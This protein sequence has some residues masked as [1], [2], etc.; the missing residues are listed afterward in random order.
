MMKRILW[1]LGI[2]LSIVILVSFD[3]RLVI[4]F[5]VVL[6]LLFVL[7]KSMLFQTV[8]FSLDTESLI[9]FYLKKRLPLDEQLYEKIWKGLKADKNHVWHIFVKGEVYGGFTRVKIWKQTVEPSKKEPDSYDERPSYY[10]EADFYETP[11]MKIWEFTIADFLTESEYQSL[12]TDEQRKNSFATTE[13]IVMEWD[14]SIII[15]GEKGRFGDT[16]EYLRWWRGDLKEPKNIFL[17]TS[18]K[19]LKKLKFRRASKDIEKVEEG[20]LY[21]KGK[22][23]QQYEVVGKQDD[24]IFGYWSYSIRNHI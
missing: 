11:E 19:Y 8:T 16:F 21:R 7:A 5:A 3:W 2:F 23:V 22:G 9:E 14:G 24:E 4:P 10:E 20:R 12:L 15:Y 13:K 6:S 18:E 17:L 1:L